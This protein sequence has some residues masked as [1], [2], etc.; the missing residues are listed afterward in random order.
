MQVSLN[1]LYLELEIIDFDIEKEM[2]S[3]IF[4][5]EWSKIRLHSI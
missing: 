2:I 5:D 3:D 4:S 1:Q